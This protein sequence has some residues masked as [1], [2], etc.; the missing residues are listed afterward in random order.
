MYT[1]NESLHSL[2]IEDPIDTGDHSRSHSLHTEREQT[3]WL[4]RGDDSLRSV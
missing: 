3:I 2:Q 1:R 4:E